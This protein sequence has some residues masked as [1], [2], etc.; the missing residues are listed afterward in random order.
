MAAPALR[1]RVGR[2][3]DALFVAGVAIA[4]VSV[5]AANG[6]YLPTSWG[7]ASLAFAW[8]ALIALVVGRDHGLTVEGAVFLA[9]TFAV[10]A[11]TFLSVIWS[12][13]VGSSVLEGER[14]LVYFSAI[15]ALLVLARGRT[16]LLL[17]A[18]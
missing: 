12:R 6:G 14:A 7:W 8:A 1:L 17:G 3:P 16:T 9:A 10:T 13:D 2:A 18:L 5:A 4:L 15:G 11:W